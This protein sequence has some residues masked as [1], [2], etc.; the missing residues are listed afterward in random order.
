MK[1][2]SENNM[3]SEETTISQEDEFKT[4]YYAPIQPAIIL[5][6][7]VAHLH[8]QLI[9]TN[10]ELGQPALTDEGKEQLNRQTLHLEQEIKSLSPSIS[11]QGNR[12]EAHNR[13]IEALLLVIQNIQPGTSPEQFRQQL[14]A[15][16]GLTISE[17]THESKSL[18]AETEVI[19][20]L[21]TLSLVTTQPSSQGSTPDEKPKPS[22]THH[23][24]LSK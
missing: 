2:Y 19:T 23:D 9:R 12:V 4:I 1:N 6:D 5:F 3:R 18:A 13:T 15:V 7:R 22:E 17:S 14:E 11:E 21:Q 10:Q 20:A 8:H 24:S 16:T